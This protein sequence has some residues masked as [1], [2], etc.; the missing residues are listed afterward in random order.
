MAVSVSAHEKA[1]RELRCVV[2]HNPYV[3]LHHCHGGS[4]K[5]HG[6]HVGMG[7][8]QNPF[9]QIPLKAEYHT[10]DMGIDYGY[11]VERWEENFGTQ[12]EHLITVNDQLPYNIFAEAV[13]WE[14]ENR[15]GQPSTATRK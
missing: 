14:T 10:G 1:L 15:D 7:Q 3:T 6:W 13:R 8:K 11:G 9:L 12:W 4:M 5:E 2:T